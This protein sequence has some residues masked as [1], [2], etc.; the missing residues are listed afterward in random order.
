ML[1][2]PNNVMDKVVHQAGEI[3]IENARTYASI[4]EVDGEWKC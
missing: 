3:A 2:A 1:P 4:I